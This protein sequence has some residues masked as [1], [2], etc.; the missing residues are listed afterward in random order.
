[1]SSQA[2]HR[3]FALSF[4]LLGLWAAFGFTPALAQ[5]ELNRRAKSKVAPSY[6]DLARRTN[7]SGVVKVLITVAP[8]GSVKDARL[9]GGHPVLAAAAL[10]AVRKWRFEAAPQDSTG[11]IE[12]RFGPNQ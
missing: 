6:P 10:D 12:F 5:E 9:V 8:N 2:P 11:I 7:L 4:A 3:K 1:M